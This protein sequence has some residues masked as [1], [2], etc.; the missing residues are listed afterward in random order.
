MITDIDFVLA[1]LLLLNIHIQY[2]LLQPGARAEQAQQRA[3]DRHTAAPH[4][5]SALSVWLAEEE[6]I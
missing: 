4:N 3:Q 1:A 6:V 2:S 5:V